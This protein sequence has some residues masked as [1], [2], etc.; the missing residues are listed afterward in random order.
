MDIQRFTYEYINEKEENFFYTNP[1]F[2]MRL[3]D[4]IMYNCMGLLNL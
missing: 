2:D 1:F 4:V 3:I